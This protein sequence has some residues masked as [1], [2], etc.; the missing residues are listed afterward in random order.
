M[1]KKEDIY[2]VVPKEV[3]AKIFNDFELE[4]EEGIHG[5]F[6][7]A[8]V[9]D[10]GLTLANM[11]GAN[12]NII[13]AFGLFHDCKRENDNEDPEHG[14]RGGDILREYAEFINLTEEEVEKAAIACE[15]HTNV[16]HNNDLDIGTCWDS[17]RLDLFR[18]GIYPEENYLNTIE[19]Q[20]PDFIDE[21]SE[22]SEYEHVSD[23][24][25]DLF[26][27]VEQYLEL[28][29]TQDLVDN[30][31]FLNQKYN[32]ENKNSKKIKL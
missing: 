8:R 4:I 11:N 3:I 10:N 29:E 30:L 31:N 2:K 7:W 28:K 24:A 14:H 16:L 12:P 1:I 20:D 32:S 15:G 18:V 23:W 19:A 27:D 6:H 21:R 5:F 26:S 13:I 25:A 22:L 17:D 9:I